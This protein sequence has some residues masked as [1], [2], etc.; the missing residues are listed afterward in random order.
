LR[1]LS[2][3]FRAGSRHC[4]LQRTPFP[5]P[6]LYIQTDAL[7]R[8]FQSQAYC[9]VPCWNCYARCGHH[10]NRADGNHAIADDTLR[11]ERIVAWCAS[12]PDEVPF[13]L[14]QLMG[15][16]D[17]HASSDGLPESRSNK[18]IIVKLGILFPYLVFSFALTAASTDSLTCGS[19]A[20]PP[21][22]R[23]RPAVP[24][25]AGEL[26]NSSSSSVAYTKPI[27]PML[28]GGEIK[29]GLAS[30][31]WLRSNPRKGNSIQ[32]TG[33]R[34]P[35]KPEPKPALVFL[36]RHVEERSCP[37]TRPTG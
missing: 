9:V 34:D 15:R 24:G 37:A 29:H 19:R 1:I 28:R 4:T 27:W 16:R 22:D 21:T 31:Y 5:Y 12:N 35:G 14:H 36:F 25:P 2:R 11:F 6:P 17:K 18:E 26:S 20:R 13:A 23:G 3:L 8:I 33:R 30:V 7:P 10:R 32:H